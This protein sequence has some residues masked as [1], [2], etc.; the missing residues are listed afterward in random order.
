[1]GAVHDSV[2]VVDSDSSERIIRSRGEKQY[3]SSQKQQGSP[4]DSFGIWVFV[5]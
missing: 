1:M 5:S 3:A 2:F 4:D